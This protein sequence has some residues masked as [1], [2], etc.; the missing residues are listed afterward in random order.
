VV[1]DVTPSTVGFV[2][3]SRYVRI[4]RHYKT[5]GKEVILAA[6]QQL[7]DHLH[8]IIRVTILAFCVKTTATTSKHPTSV[9]HM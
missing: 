7:L 6:I 1:P 4:T 8:A 3:A 2:N 5:T 9:V